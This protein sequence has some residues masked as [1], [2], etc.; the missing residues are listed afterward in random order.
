MEHRTIETARR[1]PP[2]PQP[3]QEYTRR[4]QDILAGRQAPA[5]TLEERFTEYRFP[6]EHPATTLRRLLEDQ[7]FVFAPGL[8]NAGGVKLAAHAGFKA[9]YLSGF[10]YAVE[11]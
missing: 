4:W 7:S 11:E 3:F 5:A 9:A 6:T 2:Q 10:S 1:M 8:Y